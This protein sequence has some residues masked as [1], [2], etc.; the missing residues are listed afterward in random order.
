MKGQWS[1]LFVVTIG[2]LLLA[3]ACVPAVL[4]VASAPTPAP[5]TPVPPTMTPVTES[6]T[7]RSS[8][9]HPEVLADVSW[10]S[11]HLDDPTVRIVDARVP[12]EGTLYQTGHIPGAVYADLFSD[13]CCPSEIMDAESFSKAMSRLGIGDDMTVVI[14]D[15]EGGLWAARLWWALR[16]YGHGQAKMLN[17]G[18]RQW[19]LA[20]KPLEMEPPEVKP[21]VFNAEV[22]A[23]WL[24]TIDEV[25]KAID[26]PDV[27]LLDA[28]TW[29]NYTGDL[30]GY[31][32]PGHIATALSFPAPDTLDPVMKTILTADD[33]SRML[34]RLHLN[35]EKRVITY[36]GG[37]FFGA[38]A[39]F[40][41]YL[42]GFDNVGLYDGSLTQWASDSSN[43]MEKEP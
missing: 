14:Y 19:V 10:V 35:P 27:S 23:Q 34:T 30:V 6:F 15:T 12:F 37:G 18:L 13:I 16:Y 7:A 22:Q 31:A 42:M 11:A 8:Y 25:K 39:A 21:A 24:A 2:F 36:C 29:P 5:P 17:G 32:R 33:L 9:A 40:V 4:P 43:P 3:G 20:G 26:D 1:K 28:L 38:H 41:L